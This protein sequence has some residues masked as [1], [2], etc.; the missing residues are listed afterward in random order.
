MFPRQRPAGIPAETIGGRV[1]PCG[2][3][4]KGP[5]PAVARY[6]NQ[7][8]ALCPHAQEAHEE[9]IIPQEGEVVRLDGP[10]QF[11]RK[12]GPAIARGVQPLRA[13]GPQHHALFAPQQVDAH[14]AVVG[15]IAEE[16]RR[17]RAVAVIREEL[18]PGQSLQRTRQR[19]AQLTCFQRGARIN[20]YRLAGLGNAEAAIVQL[21]QQG[22]GGD[23]LP[24]SIRAAQHLFRLPQHG[25]KGARRGGDMDLPARPGECAHGLAAHTDPDG[26]LS[27]RLMP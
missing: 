18:R 20:G 15:A 17:A 4:H 24:G 3:D 27:F 21:F 22:N 5:A 8:D 25:G 11:R 6:G 23:V 16:Y 2:L 9:V 26:A 1:A 14:C 7:R 13:V 12:W 19:G 10:L